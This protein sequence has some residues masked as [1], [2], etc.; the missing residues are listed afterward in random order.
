MTLPV[1]HISISIDRKPSDVYDFVANPR[2]LPAWASGLSGSKIHQ[3]GEDWISDSPMGRVKIRFA[4]KNSFGIVD[5]D[6]TLASGET[7][8][9]PFRVIANRDGSELTFALFRQPEMSDADYERDAKTI[10]SDLAAVKKILE[11]E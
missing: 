2:N 10:A 3:E 4:P 11:S 6:V 1:R 9:N 8:A 7:F 5:H